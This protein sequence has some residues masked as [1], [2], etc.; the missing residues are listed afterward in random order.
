MNT[1]NLGR[2]DGS[3]HFPAEAGV[4]ENTRT[5]ENAWHTAPEVINVFKIFMAFN[6]TVL[7]KTPP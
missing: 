7:L 1:A 5:I 3:G 4:S 6:Y 2:S